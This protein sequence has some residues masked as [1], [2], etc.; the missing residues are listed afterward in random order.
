M[1]VK[2]GRRRASRA[3]MR[4]SRLRTR[5]R[6]MVFALLLFA[7]CA[8]H[9]TAQQPRATYT[10]P[11]IAGDFPDPSVI[12]VGQDY[13]AT[14]TSGEWAPLFPIL[15][16]NDLVNWEVVGAVFQRR[17]QWSVSN[18]WAPE[19]EEDRGRFFVYYVGRKRNGPLCVAVATAEKPSG[20]YTDHGPLICEEIGSIDPFTTR[21]ENNQLYLIWKE[22]GNSRGKP[23][24]IWAQKLSE[25]GTKLTGSK[26][27]LFR[28]DAPW[29]KHVVE[30]S[31][32]MRRG[33]WFYH[34][35]S[36]NACCGR[37]C[38]YALG[39]ARSRKLLGPWEKNPVNPIIA[40]NQT[41]QCPGHGSIVGDEQGRT[42]LL[43]HAYKR[44]EDFVQIGREALLD[45]V[46][47][48]A[49]GW[50]VIN[51][52]KGPG[53]QNYSPL[54]IGQRDSQASFADDFT[55]TR[56]GASWQWPQADEPL[57]ELEPQRGGYLLLTAR[58]ESAL[59]KSFTGAILA[60]PTRAGDYAATAVVDARALKPGAKA[61]LAAFQD[62]E[63]ALGMAVGDGKVFIWRREAGKE[64]IV[65]TLDAPRAQTIHL[66]MAVDDG[67][68]FRFAFSQNGRDWIEAGEP[69]NASY[70]EGIRVAL[71]SGGARDASA[72]FESVSISP[73]QEPDN[74]K[75][76]K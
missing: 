73:S 10:N 69:L 57:I 27:E 46:Q 74:R 45:E 22:D 58:S 29:E 43:Y 33:G 21:D 76:V 31:F 67:Y 51:N 3:E 35:Y 40:A 2:P 72:R 52:G 53:T 34:F 65:K 17:P 71:T 13:W 18:F 16:S 26:K 14:A 12:R 61:G 8:A 60:M 54:N 70:L 24:R 50:P 66:R 49:D 68:V 15:R 37:G 23:T 20:P 75:A 1:R 36:G 19:I 38:D 56:L 62:D 4:N 42:F 63:N 11:V 48:G 59:K 25:D 47:W 30:G 5:V 39:V 41:W 44:S 64:Q 55:S 7:V 28:N 32:I 9:T 6:P